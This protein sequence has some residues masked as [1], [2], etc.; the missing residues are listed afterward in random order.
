MKIT[1]PI[2]F[3]QCSE[4]SPPLTSIKKQKQ[5]KKGLLS[6]A[7]A[8]QTVEHVLLQCVKYNNERY[9]LIQSMKKEQHHDF[10]LSGL[11]GKSANNIYYIIKFIK[12]CELSKRI[13]YK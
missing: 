7:L 13:E 2:H 1:R 11:L 9:R 3:L 6:H 4:A 10:S 12:E 5:T 8:D